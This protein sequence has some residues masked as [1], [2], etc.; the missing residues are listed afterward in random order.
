[1]CV[2]I[3]S[4]YKRS[5]LL[6]SL[7]PMGAEMRPRASRAAASV[8]EIDRSIDRYYSIYIYIYICI[9]NICKR[10]LLRAQPGADGR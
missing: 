5:P 9:L 8:M 6:R 10:Y 2:C 7:V 4:L 1:M 3:R